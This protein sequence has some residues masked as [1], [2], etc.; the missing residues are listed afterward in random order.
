MTLIPVVS[1]DVASIGF[2]NSELEVHFHSGG[3]YRYLHVPEAVFQDFIAAP[4]K[5]QFVHQRLK[6]KFTFQRLR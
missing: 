1:S 6:G 5:G 4:S 2:E 3:I